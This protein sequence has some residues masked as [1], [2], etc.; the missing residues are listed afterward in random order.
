MAS[1]EMSPEGTASA[2]YAPAWREHD[3]RLLLFLLTWIGAALTGSGV[4]AVAERLGRDKAVAERWLLWSVPIVLGM[5]MVTSTLFYAWHCP[6]CHERFFRTRWRQAFFL[7]RKCMHCGLPKYA[8]G[9]DE[10]PLRPASESTNANDD[11]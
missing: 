6:R 2:P 11:V 10:R 9:P 8:R 7:A 4:F 3:R 1:L 5:C